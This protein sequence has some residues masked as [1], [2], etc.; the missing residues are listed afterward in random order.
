MS[1]DIMPCGHQ[2]TSVVSSA[3]GT[4]FCADCA[5]LAERA[6]RRKSEML[7]TR[8]SPRLRD[9]LIEWA[10]DRGMTPSEAVRYAVCQLV[11]EL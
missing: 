7:F 8:V 11:G 5:R 1:D 3:E 4:C 6:A 9:R 2:R 10:D